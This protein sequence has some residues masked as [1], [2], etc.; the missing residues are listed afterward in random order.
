MSLTGDES[1]GAERQ[2]RQR[3]G[4][5]VL[6]SGRAR[7]C[8]CPAAGPGGGF[9]E[10][11]SK[12]GA[13]PEQMESFKHPMLRLCVRRWQT[14]AAACLW[15]VPGLKTGTISLSR[16]G[17][18]QPV[19]CMWSTSQNDTVYKLRDRHESATH[20]SK[21]ATGLTPPPCR[22]TGKRWPCPTGATSRSA[23]WTRETLKETVRV[24]VGSHPNEMVWGKD[25]RL[26]VANSGSNSVSVIFDGNS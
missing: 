11:A 26:F 17:G 23:C 10:D 4:G 12:L 1:A 7:H 5:D 25:G 18:G 13:S 15:H 2:C 22:R 20:R 9:L 14:D 24:P 3:L 21:S 19:R 6:G 8:W 16:A